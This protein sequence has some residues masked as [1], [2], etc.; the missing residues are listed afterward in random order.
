M[1]HKYMINNSNNMSTAPSLFVSHGAPTFAL[2]PG[3]LGPK[4]MEFGARHAG[5]RAVLVVS[6]HWQTRGVEVMT[7]A[8]PATMHDFGGFPDALYQLQ[9]PVAGAPELAAE[10]AQLLTGAGFSV[11]ASSQRGLDHGAWVP[12]R[13][14]RPK[15]ETPVFQVSMPFDLDAAGARRLGAALQSLRTLGVMI[16]GSGSL[17]HN[18]REFSPGVRV[19]AD[20]V[21]KF[22]DWIRGAVERND[23]ESLLRYRELAPDA[24]RAHPT[25]EHFLP[26]LVAMG[27]RQSN[28]RVEV[29][30][31]G[32]EY[33]ILAMDSFAWAGD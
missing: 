12:L 32:I 28:D 7:T 17:T 31:G 27:A 16:L 24:G 20:Y 11:S 5:L 10:A 18:L 30:E 33:G 1:L 25:E 15:G 4:L 9:Y 22:R 8:A 2:E 26:L 14:L 13:F 19:A 29:L 23:L 21:R 3:L 6:A